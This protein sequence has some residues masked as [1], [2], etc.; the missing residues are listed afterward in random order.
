[1][2][3][4]SAIAP[5]GKSYW[6]WVIGDG[7]YQQLKAKRGWSDAG[8]TALCG[9]APTICHAG[10][11]VNY[12][13]TLENG[14]NPCVACPKGKYRAQVKH[15]EGHCISWSV[16]SDGETVKQSGT[17]TRDVTCSA[18]GACTKSQ[19]EV[20]P[21]S[22]CAGGKCSTPR[23]CQRVSDCTSGQYVTVKAT[24]TSN[25]QCGEC[26]GVTNYQPY[27]NQDRCLK[28]PSCTRNQHVVSGSASPSSKLK[29]TKCPEGTSQPA[30]VFRGEECS[31]S[32]GPT[33]R[34][35]SDGTKARPFCS[36]VHTCHWGPGTKE[37]CAAAICNASGV[38][39]VGFISASNNMCD[40]RKL[41]QPIGASYDILTEWNASSS[42]A[43]I[44]GGI[45][46]KSYKWKSAVTAECGVPVV[47]CAAG[48]FLD[49]NST[50]VCSPCPA[51][52]YNAE[53]NHS[54]TRCTA[55]AKCAAN[56]HQVAAGTATS[57]IICENNSG[58]GTSLCKGFQYQ[59]AAP[60]ATTGRECSGISTCW[61]GEYVSAANTATS[62]RVCADCPSTTHTAGIFSFNSARCTPWK[63]CGKDQRV[64][65]RGTRYSDVVCGSC[66]KGK[67]QPLTGHR[68]S[69]CY[70]MSTTSAPDSA[71]IGITLVGTL[72]ADMPQFSSLIS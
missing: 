10:Q 37:L 44:V 28:M 39:F 46:K 27:W 36:F 53:A 32:A 8:I 12:N 56:E 11:R 18:V 34:I 66:Q 14:K 19:Y 43:S 5:S 35:T 40:K 50:T 20:S 52:H 49:D 4:S 17:R 64:I 30:L 54:E 58:N 57:N 15:S 1:M 25:R 59:V 41:Y 9:P 23:V 69:I 33:Q 48:Q 3:K 13:V 72:K 62:D 22:G 31:A 47:T 63:T 71:G 60:T 26:D 61:P 16:C 51:G 68:S 7:S 24:A 2:C 55:W 6:N 21:P 70:D 38:P 67:V 45:K 65:L 42:S 29:C